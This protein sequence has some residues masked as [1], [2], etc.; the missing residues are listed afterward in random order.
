MQQFKRKAGLP[1]NFWHQEVT[2][3]LYEVTKWKET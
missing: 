1:P 3:A 2:I